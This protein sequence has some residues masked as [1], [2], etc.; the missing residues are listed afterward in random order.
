ML[1]KI[2]LQGRLVADPELRHTQSGVAVA[3]AQRVGGEG[4]EQVSRLQGRQWDGGGAFLTGD[5]EGEKCPAG[6]LRRSMQGLLAGEDLF[7]QSL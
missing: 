6:R 1:N 3:P 2:F 4:D 5:A 7:C